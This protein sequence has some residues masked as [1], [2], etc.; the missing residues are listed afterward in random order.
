MPRKE[1]YRRNP[2]KHVQE[3]RDWREKNRKKYRDDAKKRAA[4]NRELLQILKNQPC[5]D[6]GVQYPHYIMEFDHITDDKKFN[7]SQMTSMATGKMLEEF[8]K[9]EIVCANCHRTR[10]WIRR[11]NDRKG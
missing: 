11:Q 9:C 10:T 8:E 5:T 2:Q 6:C 3:T 1:E 4:R 7:V